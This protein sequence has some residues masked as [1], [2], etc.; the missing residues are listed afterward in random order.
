MLRDIGSAD[1]CSHTPRRLHERS[2]LMC[3][4][5]ERELHWTDLGLRWCVRVFIGRVLFPLEY[6]MV[7]RT[8]NP[9]QTMGYYNR[10]SLVLLEDG[11]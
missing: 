2:D 7:C 6:R 3:D 1:R 4:S 11:T 10:L 5:Q 9:L 8:G